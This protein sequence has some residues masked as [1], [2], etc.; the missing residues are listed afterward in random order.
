MSLIVWPSLAISKEIQRN[1]LS[2]IIALG[3]RISTQTRFLVDF[4]FYCRK[5]N[6]PIVDCLAFQQYAPSLWSARW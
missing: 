2:P 1:A 3:L 6:K 4:L 5:L